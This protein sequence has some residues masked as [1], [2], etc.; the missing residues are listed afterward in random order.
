MERE[1]QPE[2]KEATFKGFA[3]QSN[4]TD[5]TTDSVTTTTIPITSIDS[6]SVTIFTANSSNIT[7]TSTAI[8]PP[9]PTAPAPSQGDIETAITQTYSQDKLNENLPM[10]SS[11]ASPATRQTPFI[12]NPVII[13]HVQKVKDK[14]EDS[15]ERKPNSR[16]L[17]TAIRTTMNASSLITFISN[18]YGR[19]RQ[20][21]I[22]TNYST[23]KKFIESNISTET[24][25]AT[26]TSIANTYNQTIQANSTTL[27]F[28][29]PSTPKPTKSSKITLLVNLTLYGSRGIK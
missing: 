26:E 9:P 11:T 12:M 4:S 2:S 1:N 23:V 21:N 20:K 25:N 8:T 22:S 19:I 24:I 15:E 14:S 28:D 6:N 17:I 13:G 27:L 18:I 5:T 16:T 3:T 7:N 10:I 29:K